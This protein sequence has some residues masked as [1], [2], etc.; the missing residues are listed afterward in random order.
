M[1][2][3]YKRYARGMQEVYKRY[4]EVYKRYT[5]NIQRYKGGIQETREV[6]KSIQGS[7]QNYPKV[8]ALNVLLMVMQLVSADVLTRAAGQEAWTNDG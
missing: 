1:Q 8:C 6:Y 3:V 7:M 2:E 4:T 5:R